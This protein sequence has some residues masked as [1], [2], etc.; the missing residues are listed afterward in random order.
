[1][2]M[3]SASL[4]ISNTLTKALHLLLT[5]KDLAPTVVYQRPSPEN[6]FRHSVYIAFDKIVAGATGSSLFEATIKAFAEF[7][8]SEICKGLG[9]KSR[10]GMAGG[11]IRSMAIKRAK[12]ELIE[13]DAFFFHYRNRVPFIKQATCHAQCEGKSLELLLFELST[14][15]SDFSTY[16]CTLPSCADGSSECFIFGMGTSSQENEAKARSIDEFVDLYMNHQ[17]NPLWCRS[18]A[19]NSDISSLHFHHLASRDQRNIKIISE[20][21]RIDISVSSLKREEINQAKWDL[22]MLDGPLKFF[23]Y[24]KVKHPDLI[25]IEFG[26]AEPDVNGSPLY[27]PFW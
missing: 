15:H 1:M 20:L 9:I 19:D 10:S 14:A 22:E 26:Q 25:K 27:H 16:L 8:E 5:A 12:A 2:G 18:L 17:L 11:I 3:G 7:G 13:R 4:D 24:V 23:S 21:C 6:L